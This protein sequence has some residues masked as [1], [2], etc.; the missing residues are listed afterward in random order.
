MNFTC[1]HRLPI[2]SFSPPLRVTPFLHRLPRCP[3]NTG[4]RNVGVVLLLGDQQTLRGG[5][6]VMF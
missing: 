3:N 1:T 5:R 4:G 2:P 6:L